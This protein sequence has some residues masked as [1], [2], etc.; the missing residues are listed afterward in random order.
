MWRCWESEL[1]TFQTDFP[2]KT[3]GLSA[4]HPKCHRATHISSWSPNLFENIPSIY[5]I[6]DIFCSESPYRWQQYKTLVCFKALTQKWHPP[7]PVLLFQCCFDDIWCFTYF[8][9]IFQMQQQCF[10]V[11][12]LIFF[13]EYCCNLKT[14]LG[15]KRSVS[16]LFRFWSEALVTSVSEAVVQLG[17]SMVLTLGSWV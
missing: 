2:V 3:A 17:Q 7:M 9:S 16:F 1:G 14:L 6:D 12:K 15:G 5:I 8:S 13:Q 11:V 10:W 4:F